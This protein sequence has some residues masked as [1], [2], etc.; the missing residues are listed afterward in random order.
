MT[1]L[2]GAP[3][4]KKPAI[5]GPPFNAATRGC[6]GLLCFP[7]RYAVF[8]DMLDIPLV[9]S[10]LGHR[11]FQADIGQLSIFL[12]ACQGKGDI[13]NSASGMH[14]TRV[15]FRYFNRCGWSASVPRRLWR[16]SS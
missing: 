10:E 14:H 16:S 5:F 12:F 7:G 6:D 11:L 15:S 9:P 13:A 3:P 8:G 4:N 2:C 1:A